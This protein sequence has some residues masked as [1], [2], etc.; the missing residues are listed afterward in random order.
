MII[1]YERKITTKI[2]K[3]QRKIT[4]IIIFKNKEVIASPCVKLPLHF[5][6]GLKNLFNS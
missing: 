3:N 5:K 6:Y 4:D 1:K 2:V